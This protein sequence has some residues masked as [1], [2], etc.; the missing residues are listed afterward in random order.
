MTR[1]TFLSALGVAP[2][3]PAIA[4]STAAVAVKYLNP[5]QGL[6]M[7]AWRDFETGSYA[8][9]CHYPTWSMETRVTLELAM[10]WAEGYLKGVWSSPEYTIER[11]VS[12]MCLEDR[13]RLLVWSVAHD[14]NA[15]PEVSYLENG[16]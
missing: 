4:S 3:A 16:R 6:R 10:K 7:E 12:R 13:S 5:R 8:V 9:V 14:P 1:R 11:L 15:W 2:A